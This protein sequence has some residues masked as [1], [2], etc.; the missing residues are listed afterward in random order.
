MGVVLLVSAVGCM[1][2]VDAYG[3]ACDDPR[4]QWITSA[5]CDGNVIV[6][7]RRRSAQCAPET[8]RQDCGT[9]GQTCAV[10]TP[11]GGGGG[12]FCAIA[13]TKDSDCGPK[14]LCSQ[15]I[16]TSSGGR[17][18]EDYVQLGEPCTQG[19]PHCAPGLVCEWQSPAAAPAGDAGVADGNFGDGAV[20]ASAP[21]PPTVCPPPAPRQMVCSQP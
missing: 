18:C 19:G 21:C 5:S 10:N 11:N 2:G 4:S 9:Y 1:A 7:E 14:G 12:P 6:I 8:T 13:C 15:F 20:D 16:Q 17:A 3:S